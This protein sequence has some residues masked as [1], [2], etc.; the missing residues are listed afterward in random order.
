MNLKQIIHE[1]LL[2]EKNKSLLL[3]EDVEVSDS[4][5][6]HIQ[7]NLTLTEN[8]FR[9]YSKKYF[10]LINEVRDL[11]NENMIGLNEEDVETRIE[12]NKMNLL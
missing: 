3:K 6:Y 5:Q 12:S 2:K 8:V 9:V 10:D 11:Y 7:E 4:L 1:S